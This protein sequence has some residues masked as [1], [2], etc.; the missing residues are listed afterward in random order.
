MLTIL[1][2]LVSITDLENQIHSN[3]W[4]DVYIGYSKYLYVS[5]SLFIYGSLMHPEELVSIFGEEATL[6]KVKLN[7]FVRDYSKISKSWGS[8]EEDIGVLGIMREEDEWCNGIIIDGL[9]DNGITNYYIRELGVTPDQYVEDKFGYNIIELD[10]DDIEFY[11]NEVD[12]STPV[13]TATINDR[14]DAPNTHP[15]YT[16]L[17]ESAAKEYGD[18]FYK[19]FDDSTYI[20]YR[21]QE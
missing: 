10:L 16:R 15:Q 20:F 17:C 21:Q 4:K 6:Y 9:D 14:I 2:N 1:I 13:K 8:E 18:D 7:G 12:V 5:H 11:D 3:I 19:D